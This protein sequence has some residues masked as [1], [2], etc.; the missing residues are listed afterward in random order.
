[1]GV[2]SIERKTTLLF[3]E[4]NANQHEAGKEADT[5]YPV[6]VVPVMKITRAEGMKK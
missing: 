4:Q 2:N 6:M 3:L 5:G 1:V